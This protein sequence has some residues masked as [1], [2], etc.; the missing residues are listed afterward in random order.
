VEELGVVEE[1]GV[2]EIVDLARRFER[3]ADEDIGVEED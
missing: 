3:V 1:V 2:V